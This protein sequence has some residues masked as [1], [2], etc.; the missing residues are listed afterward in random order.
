MPFVEAGGLSVHYALGGP[1]EAPLV[2]FSHSIGANLSMWDPQ[3]AALE[4]RFRVLRYDTRG[5]GLTTVTSGPC[6]LDQLAADV[7]GLLDALGQERAQFCGLS[8]G[9]LIGMR[10]FRRAAHR[11]DKLVLCNTAA[12]I[13]TTDGWNARIESVRRQGMTGVAAQVVERWFSPEFRARHPETVAAG[14]N[15]LET[16][17]PEGYMAACA[18]LRDADER[19]SLPGILVPTLVVAG[20]RDPATPAA[21]GRLLAEAIPGAEYVELPAAHLSNLEAAERFTGELLRFL[22]A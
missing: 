18:A 16:T 11:I 12:R 1:P 3:V 15:M 13:G 17:P 4:Q 8:L 6:T 22:A 2:V 9:G 5:H 10:L 19:A 7:L 14:L 21:E 20:S